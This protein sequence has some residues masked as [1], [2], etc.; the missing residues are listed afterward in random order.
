MYLTFI[1]FVINTIFYPG[2]IDIDVD[3]HS[4]NW[5]TKCYCVVC[6]SL[7]YYSLELLTQL[8]LQL[9]HI[10]KPFI[11]QLVSERFIIRSSMDGIREG[12]STIRPPLLDGGN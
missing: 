4:S 2:Q 11:F 3:V 7:Y 8:K 9:S 6:F 10:T 1:V 5:V 12:N